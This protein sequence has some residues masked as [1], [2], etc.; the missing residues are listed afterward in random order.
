M[1]AR[2]A[3]SRRGYPNANRSF[4]FLIAICILLPQCLSHNAWSHEKDLPFSPG[5][6]LTMKVKWGFITAGEAVLEVLP[7]IDIQGVKLHHFALTVKTSP[8]IDVFYKVRDRIDSIVDADMTHSLVYKKKKDGDSKKDICVYFNW[9]KNKAL[10]SNF[11]KKRKPIAILPG[12]FDPLAIFYAFRTINVINEKEVERP[13]SDGKK[14]VLGKLNIIKT[15]KIRLSGKEYD[16]IL[17]EPR[18]EH[19]EGIFERSDEATLKIWVTADKH[20]IPL[21]IKSSVIV[22]NFVGELV[23]ATGIKGHVEF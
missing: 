8:F 17:V 10:Y 18:L 21:R 12:T 5:E 11:G 16:A 23:S 20:H 3:S 2:S 19:V 6:R 13:I 1:N 9:K 4:S 7:P 14:C 15:E 22:G